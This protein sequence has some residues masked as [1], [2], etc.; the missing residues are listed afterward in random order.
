MRRSARSSS[1][2]LRSLRLAAIDR[3]TV[4]RTQRPSP[5]VVAEI[6][7]RP[8][9]RPASPVGPNG[10]ALNATA[11]VRA[12]SAASDLGQ[13]ESAIF[14]TRPARMSKPLSRWLSPSFARNMRPKPINAASVRAIWPAAFI[15]GSSSVCANEHRQACRP[16]SAPRRRS[17]IGEKREQS[18]NKKRG[19]VSFQQKFRA[20]R[21]QAAEQKG[22]SLKG[23]YKARTGRHHAPAAGGHHRSARC[24]PQSASPAMGSLVALNRRRR[25]RNFSCF[26][27]Q[28]SEFALYLFLLAGSNSR[29]TTRL[30]GMAKE[31]E[32][33]ETFCA[34][35]KTRPVFF[36]WNRR[37]PLKSPDSDE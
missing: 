5:R 18:K 13:I 31:K 27:F 24:A 1:N 16:W 33:F 10:G 26:A 35:A 25:A 30:D 23:R 3:R 12:C 9:R 15:F 36:I 7:R 11:A 8:R 22:V 37:N 14:P 32:A 2:L 29:L 34:Q 28:N 6:G 21:S 19:L 17:T 4:P 20:R